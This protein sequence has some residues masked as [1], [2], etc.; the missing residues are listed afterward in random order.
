M[1]RE[2]G[3][4]EEVRPGCLAEG[5]EKIGTGAGFV[6]EAV[7]AADQ[8]PRLSP[9]V[10]APAFKLLREGQR[11]KLLPFLVEK[12]GDAALDGRG[13]PAAAFRQLR[14]RS[15]EHTS[16]LQSLLRN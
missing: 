10:V 11:A 7:G 1:F 12:D 13:K 8:E 6:V 2:H 5:E 14:Q 4:Y 3:A 15:E 16:E 9:A